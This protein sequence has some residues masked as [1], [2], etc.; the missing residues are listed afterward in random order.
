M[1][2]TSQ[3][4]ISE[5]EIVGIAFGLASH[6][7][8]C[9]ASVSDCSISHSSQLSNPFL[10]LP[11]EFGKCE[12]CG[13]SE[14]GKCEGHF[15][16][17]ELP[18]PIYHP[19]HVTELK[20]MLTLL[21]LKCLKLKKTKIQQTSNGV[22]QRLLS[23]CEECSQVSVQNIK[24][25]DG[26]SFLQLK[27]PSKSRLR[28]GAWNF[29]ESYGFRYGDSHTRALL[30][31]EVLQILKRI[32]RDSRKKLTEKG[33]FPQ[34]GFILQ[35]I[36]VPPNC[37]SV[38]DIS[39][40]VSIMSSDPSLSMLK[41][42]LRQV[43][44]IKSSRSGAP[45]FES[46]EVEANDLQVAVDRYLLARG[47]TK[48]AHDVEPRYGVNK[49]V[50]ESSKNAWL[51]KMKTLFI[52]KGCGFASRSVITGDSY[53]QVNEIGIPFEIA[54]R[55]TFEERVTD[56]NKEYLQKLV[57][58]KLCLAYR[59]GY[60]TYSL[61]EGSK[62]HTLLRPGQVVHRRIMDGD[63]VFINRPPTTHKHS[64]QALSVYIHDD[65]TV[66]INPL[67]C[68]PLSA[69]FDGDCIHLFYPQSL[70]A[71]AEVLE[72]FSVEKQLLSSHSGYLNLQLT[73]DSLLSLKLMFKEY[74]LDR[75]A[76]QQ[77]A[78]FAS[79]S[80]PQ[81]AV[82]KSTDF[83]PRWTAVQVMQTALPSRF[84]C[85]GDTFLITKSEMLRIEGHRDFN[86]VLISI[87]FEKGSGAVL[88]FFN[89]LQPLLM[90]HLFS[91][92][93]SVSLEDFVIPS[94]AR[95]NIREKINGASPLLRNLR[96]TYNELVELQL[97]EDIWHVKQQLKNFILSSP[98]LGYLIDSKGDSAVTKVVQQ[99]GFLGLQISDRGKFYSKTLVDDVAL[100]F[101]QNYPDVASYP[102]AEY[103]LIH[104]SFFHGLD[105]YEAMVHSISSREIIVRSSRG[106]SE[107]GTLFKN[108]M[109][110]LRDVVICYDGT[111]RNV[112]SNSVIQFDYGVNM[113]S[114]SQSLF[115]AGEPVGV[116]AATAMS[117]PA[118]KAVLDS[119]PSSNSSWELMK[120]I[121]LCKINFKNDQ[122]DR[123]VILYLNN[124]GCGRKYC[125]EKAAYLVKNHL[126][127]VSL[128]DVAV[129]FTIEYK[130]DQSVMESFGIDAGLVGH[131]H[132]EK[133]KL[134][135]LNTD[136]EMI[137]QKCQETISSYGKKKKSNHIFRRTI[138]SVSGCCCFQQPC[139]DELP[140]MPCLMFFYQDTAETPF[141]KTIDILANMIYPVLLETVIKG[142]NRISSANIIWASPE[143][144]AWVRNPSRNLKGEWA[145]DVG[146][147][148]SFVKRTGDAWRIV[149]DSCLPVLDLIDTTRSIPYAIKQ[150]QQ[151]LGVSSAF[152]QAVQRLSTSVAMV[153]KGVLKEHLILLANSMTCAGNLVGFNTSGYKA[154]SRALNIQVPFTEA[155]LFTP[156]KCFEKAAE[157]CHVDALSSVVASCAWGKNVAVGT[158]SRFD[159]L[160][161][162]KQ[163]NLNQAGS[164]DVYNFLGILSSTKDGGEPTS[165]C[166]GEEVDALILENEPDEWTLS[167]EHNSGP[168]KPTFEYEA[169]FQH[170]FGNQHADN[171]EKGSNDKSSRDGNWD[172][173][174][175]WDTKSAWKTNAKNNSG[176]EPNSLSGW[177][178][179]EA[180][181][182]DV[183]KPTTW[184]ESARSKQEN[185]S[186]PD[187][188]P[189]K[190]GD[191][192]SSGGW[193]Q[194]RA[195]SAW[196]ES[197]R[198][199]QENV[200]LPDNEPGKDGD[201]GSSG[202]WAQDRAMSGWVSSS[203]QKAPTEHHSWNSSS[204]DTALKCGFQNASSS[205]GM[206]SMDADPNSLSGWGSKEA[207]KDDVLKPTAWGESARSKQENVS[208]PDNEPGKDGDWV[209]SGAWAQDH[210][211]S[212][213]VS[214]SSQ[215]APTD[216]HSWS[217][218]AQDAA[219]KCGFQ[220]ASSSWG[221][222]SMD[223]DHGSS[224]DNQSLDQVSVGWDDKVGGNKCTS[225]WASSS[226]ERVIDV[227]QNQE[228]QHEESPETNGS[229]WKSK[230]PEASHGWGSKESIKGTS[231]PSWGELS[232]GDGSGGEKQKQWGQQT[233]GWRK[234]R[235][236]MSRGYGSNSGDWK[237][238]SRPPKP[239]GSRDDSRSYRMIGKR[240]DIFTPEEQDILSSVETLMAS[241][242]RILHNS[243]YN[244]GD[245]LSA[246][247]QS[248][249][250]DNVLNH[251]PDKASKMG[252]G[253][254][255]LTVSKHSTFQDT[256]C[257]FVV[258]PDG[259]REDFSYTKCVKNF[260]KE[261]YP[262]LAEEFIGKYFAKSH[263]GGNQQGNPQTSPASEGNPH[264]T[265]AAS[266]GN[267]VTVQ[268]PFSE[269]TG[270]EGN[271]EER[272]GSQ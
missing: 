116:L 109:A 235:S 251:H 31:F 87:F 71:K 203:S 119:T 6:K 237:M 219:L 49:Q 224:G 121:L 159:L 14:L 45:N 259:L 176:A 78:M 127:K 169:E 228:V 185:V 150:V 105:P 190:D 20:R 64:L 183:L 179:K 44:I 77:L 173:C 218:S 194:D 107:P 254:D 34:E 262:D 266:E 257:F 233:G 114:K 102:S 248:Y 241:T 158:G 143:T 131:V 27:L 8:I 68:G 122:A 112:C 162:A 111:V 22:A 204:Q 216:H 137:L 220:N 42:V 69:D 245:P 47:T 243:G 225:G 253:I 91:E 197:A 67:I 117:N 10:G 267:P 123:R 89:S 108:L 53:K 142:D 209:S 59:D 132:L 164:I 98:S 139:T 154:L 17:I 46:H 232:A 95:K 202:G 75:P 272:D 25:T 85:S 113:G 255:H 192:G 249:I 252:D 227:H 115:P 264:Q 63:I 160:W 35:Y 39:D 153:A 26:A 200:S 206:K 210:S 167:P 104:S 11:L 18:I 52:R 37:L 177:G 199:K 170:F 196:G 60:S 182:D 263:F 193:A 269:D 129:C 23:C 242:K 256:R 155:T 62:G 246:D 171:W 201:W 238:K 84:N 92:G 43:D 30:P 5:G 250:L 41:K 226:N 258:S 152:D 191:W 83:C 96:S 211:M 188:E 16:Y 270:G 236:E 148:K 271:R 103:G 134:Q 268:T 65:H 9:T 93:F 217:S 244:D 1:E 161:N 97:E 151:L 230:S 82:L 73:R 156:R 101:Q 163:A 110:I 146:L 7:E 174:N 186:L 212:G 166:L 120:E 56:H 50:I 187:N 106:L 157:K 79:P 28:D 76:A 15:G 178:S 51:E 175:G 36:P 145:L 261:K 265:A 118:Y 144:T 221:M 58:N 80:L 3:S 136:I 12:S 172:A 100:H 13:T 135:E 205:W 4:N 247:D 195:M 141:E 61:R 165:G 147:D 128:K 32:P 222:K 126:E 2:D 133:M 38:P 72:L 239:A 66:K 57:D 88:K 180:K 21:C 81:P 94:A 19:S 229:W 208:L 168:D 240:V 231:S 70:A 215:K 181:K 125:Q 260:I 138:F 48:A 198:S 130:S 213:W 149:L 86:E 55:I 124:C 29:L 24:K 99:I 140:G 234:S 33:Y 74:F 90:E 184:G 207:K 223:A 189:G 40:G 214:S 54:Q